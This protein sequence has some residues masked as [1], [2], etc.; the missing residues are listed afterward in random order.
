[1]QP[2]MSASVWYLK[3]LVLEDMQ[4]WN[5]RV[6][7]PQRFA[8]QRFVCANNQGYCERWAAPCCAGKLRKFLKSRYGTIFLPYVSDDFKTE[9]KC[10]GEK[11]I[12]K[13]WNIFLEKSSKGEAPCQ[14]KNLS[15]NFRKIFSTK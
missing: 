14:K 12:K 13:C 7:T 6:E 15:K 5:G 8:L 11:S 3:C 1:M 2:N 10:K 4:P 9:K